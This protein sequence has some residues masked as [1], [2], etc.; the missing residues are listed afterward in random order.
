MGKVTGAGSG[1]ECWA[2]GDAYAGLGSPT[3]AHLSCLH[4]CVVT[5]LDEE[6]DSVGEVFAFVNRF[7]LMRIE[8]NCFQAR[9]RTFC[10]CCQRQHIALVWKVCNW[11]RVVIVCCPSLFAL[12][13]MPYEVATSCSI[14]LEGL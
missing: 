6:A 2:W 4:I 11:Y 12:V 13:S 8:E 3:L 7:Q 10:L 5:V 14:G 9:V 1:C